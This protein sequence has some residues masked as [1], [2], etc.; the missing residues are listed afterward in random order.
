ECGIAQSIVTDWFSR[1][2]GVSGTAIKGLGPEWVVEFCWRLLRDDAGA[3]QGVG[4]SS[5]GFEAEGCNAGEQQ[6]EPLI[7]YLLPIGWGE[8]EVETPWLYQAEWV[9]GT[10]DTAGDEF[11]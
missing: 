5:E 2:A 11:R 8:G 9:G 3:Y 10:D 6:Y 1:D 7:P 4:G